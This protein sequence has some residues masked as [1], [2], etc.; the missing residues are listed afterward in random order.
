MQSA[1]SAFFSLIGK[2]QRQQNKIKTLPSLLPH[3]PLLLTHYNTN[4]QKKKISSK[5]F[6][7][8]FMNSFSLAMRTTVRA[9]SYG[10]YLL[11]P[12][13]SRLFIFPTLGFWTLPFPL[14]LKFRPYRTLLLMSKH[15]NIQHFKATIWGKTG[16]VLSYWNN[17]NNRLTPH[18]SPKPSHTDPFFFPFSKNGG[19]CSIRQPFRY[20]TKINKDNVFKLL[21]LFIKMYVFA[22]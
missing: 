18:N 3:S 20:I 22:N 12:S 14:Q 16:T 17:W 8:V 6:V 11:V 4:I 10:V 5:I 2:P 7:L 21:L 1:I 13:I 15:S 19:K 9:K